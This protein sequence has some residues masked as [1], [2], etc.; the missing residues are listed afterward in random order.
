[1]KI[2]I[3][4]YGT[5]IDKFLK[6]HSVFSFIIFIISFIVLLFKSQNAKNSEILLL[7]KEL[8]IMNRKKEGLRRKIS[9][10]DRIYMIILNK[11]SNNKSKLL[12]IKPETLLM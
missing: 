6:N 9:N 11:I 4:D 10:S 5:I 3:R 8:Q 12:I 1:M 2:F 7:R